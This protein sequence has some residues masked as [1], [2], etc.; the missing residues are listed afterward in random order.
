MHSLGIKLTDIQQRDKRNQS[1]GNILFPNF[2]WVQEE[3][4]VISRYDVTKK[5]PEV[6]S[7]CNG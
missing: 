7:Y 3:I 5:G 1:N 4:Y 6:V 2:F